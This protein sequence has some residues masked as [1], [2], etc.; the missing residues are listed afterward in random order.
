[1]SEKT[2]EQIE[3]TLNKIVFKNDS[4]FIIGS[5]TDKNNNKFT[6]I[7]TMINPQINMDYIFSGYH[8]ENHKYGEQ[9]K[10]I[11]YEALIP[12]DTSGIFKY[13]VRICKFVGSSVGNKIIDKYGDQTLIIMKTNPKKLSKEIS[14]IT[15][16]RA[17]K[18]QSTLLENEKT[19]KIMIELG[20]MLDIPGM[21]KSLQS[22]LIKEYKSNAVAIIKENPYILTQ[23]SGIGFPL[24]DRVALNIGYARDSIERKKAIV[25]H[26]LKQNMQEG[27]VWIKT[28]DLLIK[29]Q[30]LIQVPDLKAG[31][32][33]L[34]KDNIIVFC[35]DHYNNMHNGYY[36]LAIPAQDEMFIAE[37][38]AEMMEA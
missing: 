20:K 30:E 19:E 5:F 13:I 23:F 3:G 12:V 31:I 24:A 6:A 33:C 29:I 11:D 7:G 21:R 34:M 37:K 25:L 2:T 1:M 9:F 15:L 17:L 18:I 35:E 14:G 36:S 8:E 38:L 10:F 4:G 26:V 32:E 22:D 28:D 16:T 27:S